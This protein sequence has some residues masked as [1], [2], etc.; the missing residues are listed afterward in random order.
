MR[1]ASRLHRAGERYYVGRRARETEVYVVTGTHV[2]A[3]EHLGYQTS[4]AF[5]WGDLTPG[6]LEL[7]FALLV[8]STGRRPPPPI[9][10]TFRADLIA[11]LHCAGFVLGDGDI[12]LWLLTAFRED[13]VRDR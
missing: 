11:G 9:C 10:E 5:D 2:E 13:D 12:A 3:L 7:A 6:A 8:R 1:R 4:A